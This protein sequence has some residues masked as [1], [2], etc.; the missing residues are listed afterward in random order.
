MKQIPTELASIVGC[1]HWMIRKI[2]QGTRP[3]LGLALKIVNA[4]DGEAPRLVDMIPE[5]KDAFHV[6]IRQ[7]VGD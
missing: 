2:N 4:M 5:L 6:M 3:S 1:T 7:G